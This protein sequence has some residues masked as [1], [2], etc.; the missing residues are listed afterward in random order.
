METSELR[1]HLYDLSPIEIE[2][3]KT[4]EEVPS[5]FYAQLDRSGQGPQ[6]NGVYLVGPQMGTL[7][8]SVYGDDPTIYGKL[9]SSPLQTEG[10]IIKRA[11]RFYQEPMAACNAIAIRYVYSGISSTTV[12]H[13]QLTLREGDLCLLSSG[14]ALSQRLDRVEDLVFTFIFSRE[15]LIRRIVE[16]VQQSNVVTRFCMNHIMEARQPHNYILFHG[17]QNE[18]IRPIVERLLC[19]YIDVDEF[20]RGM[21]DALVP[22]L[23]Y[24]MLRCPYDF[25]ETPVGRRDVA[26]AQ[27]LDYVDGHFATVTLHE[28]S[29]RF[30]YTE[31]YVSRLFG[32]VTGGTFKAY[33]NERRMRHAASL[34][35]N[36]DL[37]VREVAVDCGLENM[38]HFY[39]QFSTRF[40][41]TPKQYR[42]TARTKKP[43]ESTISTLS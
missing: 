8:A 34:L 22:Q 24:E 13:G 12:E 10:M 19:E 1:Q 16:R 31:K 40:G 33:V 27:M 11:S 20:S 3:L 29:G 23:V 35:S 15:Q 43:D 41:C 32:R 17:A 2:R 6:P 38:T 4:G 36:T 28:L 26:L 18:R 37:A 7:A 9:N 39:R 14:L 42:K 25:D 21:V 5:P 30:G